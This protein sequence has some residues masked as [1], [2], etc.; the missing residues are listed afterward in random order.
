MADIK[1][2]VVRAVAVLTVALGAG[3]LVQNMGKTA[4]PVKTARTEVLP[5]PKAIQTVA[6]TDTLPVPTP[7]PKSAMKEPIAAAI[8]AAPADEALPAPIVLAATGATAPLDQKSPAKIAPMPA[9]PAAPLAA[10]PNVEIDAPA[11][12]AADAC[13]VR[14]ELI[15]EPNAMIGLTLLAPCHSN[16]RVVVKHAGLAVSGLT[17]ANGALFTGIPALEKS[18]SIEVL[19]ADGQSATAKIEMLELSQLRRFGVQWQAGDAFQVHA[20]ENGSGYNGPGHISGADPHQPGAGGPSDGGFLTLLGDSTAE[21][22]LLAE[23]YTYP[24]NPMAKPEVI[25]ESAVTDATCGREL[26][27]ETLNS[28]GGKVYVTDLT[29]AMPDCSA[30]GDYM[31]LKNLVLDLNIAASE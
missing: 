11:Q 23:I 22:P 6:A 19:F 16:E 31:V 8:P 4:T 10:A 29:L 13:A 20:F 18:A 5:E 7:P 28:I 24:A 3:H 15:A 1:R 30:I 27:G 12:I 2:K 17:T 26:L 14:L 21:N 9:L 25:I